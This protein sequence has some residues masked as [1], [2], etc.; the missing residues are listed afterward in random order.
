MKPTDEQIKEFW[1]GC[2]FEHK[3]ETQAKWQTL[4]EAS[5]TVP[6]IWRDYAVWIA[7]TGEEWL[8]LPNVRLDNLFKYAVTRLRADYRNWKSGLMLDLLHRWLD[9]WDKGEEDD[10]ALALFWAIYELLNQVEG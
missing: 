2:G 4:V 8:S 10:P 9:D 3:P 1:E 7:P 5:N 6:D